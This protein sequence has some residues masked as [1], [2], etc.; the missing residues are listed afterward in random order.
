MLVLLR[1][2]ALGDTGI[3]SVSVSVSIIGIRIVSII[4]IISC[5]ICVR[6]IVNGVVIGVISIVT[7]VVVYPWSCCLCYGCWYVAIISC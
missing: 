7:M 5:S 4:V 6:S 3:I 2:S 1:L